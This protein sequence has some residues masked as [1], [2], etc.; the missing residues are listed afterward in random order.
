MSPTLHI[1]RG[2][3]RVAGHR[4]HMAF[5][6][7]PPPLTT[8]RTFTTSSAYSSKNNPLLCGI[9]AK[10]AAGSHVRCIPAVNIH[11]AHYFIR[12]LSQVDFDNL[13]CHPGPE[14]P[15]EFHNS[16]KRIHTEIIGP[17]RR[18]CE[19]GIIEPGT[20]VLRE[21]VVEGLGKTQLDVHTTSDALSPS[22]NNFETPYP[23]S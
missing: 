16:F 18:H 22:Y 1:F 14:I 15:K 8:T 3:V 21:V 11:V 19:Q 10:A 13:F 17:A 9:W 6:R 4:A 23:G 7:T 20:S 5:Y 2:A 12:K